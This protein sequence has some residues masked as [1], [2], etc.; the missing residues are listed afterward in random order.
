MN[1]TVGID[2]GLSGA[3]C[4]LYPEGTIDIF[5]WEGHAKANALISLY[6]NAIFAAFVEDP[7]MIPKGHVAIHKLQRNVGWWRGLFMGAG[8]PVRMIPPKEWQKILLPKRVKTETTKTR[9][10]ET[11]RLLVPASWDYVY[12]PAHH[13]IADAILLAYYGAKHWGRP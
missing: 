8:I 13:N 10:V 9:S 1:I 2:P 12:K 5:A 3:V 11:V 4:F 6:Q 7:P